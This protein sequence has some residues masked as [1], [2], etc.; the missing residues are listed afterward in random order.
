LIDLK[1]GLTENSILNIY[2]PDALNMFNVCSD[3]YEV[4]EN[5]SDTSKRIE[6]DVSIN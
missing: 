6:I 2:H 1:I 3:L 5:L 4:I